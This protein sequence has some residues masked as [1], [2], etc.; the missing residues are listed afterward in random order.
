MEGFKKYLRELTVSPDYQSR[1]TFNPFY[2]LDIP[3]D[4]MIIL[5]GR[6]EKH[7]E[8][9]NMILQDPEIDSWAFQYWTK[10]KEALLMNMSENKELKNSK[11]VH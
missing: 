11:Y 9:V 10:V 5:K 8:N 7:I 1:G 4:D 6:V 3:E 2:V